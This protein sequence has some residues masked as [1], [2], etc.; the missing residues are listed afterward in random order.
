MRR[1]FRFIV[2]NSR[3]STWILISSEHLLKYVPLY[4]FLYPFEYIEC[5]E[6]VVK[7]SLI[8]FS[9]LVS[10]DFWC[11]CRVWIFMW[12]RKSLWMVGNDGERFF[13]LNGIIEMLRTEGQHRKSRILVYVQFDFLSCCGKILV[14][15]IHENTYTINNIIALSVKWYYGTV[16][17]LFDWCNLKY[18]C[19]SSLPL[20]YWYDKD[21]RPCFLNY[22]LVSLNW[23]TIYL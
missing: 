2:K 15:M 5:S 19:I 21:K 18:M 10:Q 12:L 14:L 16:N 22:M 1:G 4:V 13:F 6:M 20:S 8:R 23:W 7:G 9:F 11:I 3:F 17:G